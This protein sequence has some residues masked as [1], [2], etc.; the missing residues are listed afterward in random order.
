MTFTVQAINVP[1]NVLNWFIYAQAAGQG[2]NPDGWTGYMPPSTVAHF[3]SIPTP[4]ALHIAAEVTDAVGNIFWPGI[5]VSPWIS[6]PD[7]ATI[8][9]DW[10]A[11]TFTVGSPPT[12][13]FAPGVSKTATAAIDAEP[14]GLNCGAE[15]YLV[16]G[17]GNKVATSGVQPFTS[18]GPNQSLSFMLSMPSTPGAYL[19]YLDITSGGQVIKAYQGSE[20]VTIP[21]GGGGGGGG[22]GVATVTVKAT[23]YGSKARYWGAMTKSIPSQMPV[24][25]TQEIV[26]TNIPADDATAPGGWFIVDMYDADPVYGGGQSLRGQ[27]GYPNLGMGFSVARALKD[28]ETLTWVSFPNGW[29]QDSA[30]KWV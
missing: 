30:G 2:Y 23:A 10:R 18:T 5:A 27:D 24:P 1:S 3:T 25:I 15:L 17:S 19:V 14:V 20:D 8:V 22:V 12:P 29:W 13:S 4:L 11:N 7:G 28:G 26:W 21:G 9:Y 6:P 16:D